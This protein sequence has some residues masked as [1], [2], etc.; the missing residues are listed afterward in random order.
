MQNLFQSI[1]QLGKTINF[2]FCRLTEI[3]FD[4]PWAQQ[5]SRCG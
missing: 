1:R 4:A 3:Q 2:A 5:R